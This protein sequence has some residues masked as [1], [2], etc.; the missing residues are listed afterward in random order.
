MKHT[1]VIGIDGSGI[2]EAIRGVNERKEWLR[3]KTDELA[4]RLADYGVSQAQLNFSAALYDG[5]NDVSVE[6]AEKKGDG[7][8]VVKANGSAVLFI[9]FGTGVHYPDSHPEPNGFSHGTYGKGLGANDYWFYTGQ[10]GNAGGVLATD[11][12][13]GYVHPNTTITH[14]NPANMSMYNAVKELERNFES[15]A[16][17]VFSD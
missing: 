12:K 17:E 6:P 8:Y 1:Y 2:D 5:I 7:W 16:R 13:T 15:I 3:R 4:K 10:P 11:P 9:E 14:G